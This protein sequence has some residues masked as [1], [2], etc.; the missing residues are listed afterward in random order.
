VREVHGRY[1][2]RGEVHDCGKLHGEL[3]GCGELSHER[4]AEVHGMASRLLHGTRVLCSEHQCITSYAIVRLSAFFL[5]L[6]RNFI[7]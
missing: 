7:N 1:Q 5:K 3:L 4:T 2:L 6:T